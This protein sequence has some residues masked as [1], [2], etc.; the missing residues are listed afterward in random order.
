MYRRREILPN[1]SQECSQDN[2]LLVP[3]SPEVIES[4]NP[5][6]VRWQCGQ[7][8]VGEREPLRYSAVYPDVRWALSDAERG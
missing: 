1:V 2:L 6:R 4:C 5:V 7:M 3:G 8:E